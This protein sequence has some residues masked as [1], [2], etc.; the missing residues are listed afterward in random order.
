MYRIN[1]IMMIFSIL[2][3]ATSCISF[4]TYHKSSKVRKNFKKLH[5]Q[6][7]KFSTKLEQ[8]YNKQNMIYRV[9]NQRY[10]NILAQKHP[11][12]T[13]LLQKMKA[14]VDQ[15]KTETTT[16][17]A[18]QNE[19]ITLTKG[20]KKIKS[21]SPQEDQLKKLRAKGENIVD[22]ING[23]GK[24]YQKYGKQY[25]KLL[26]KAGVKRVKVKKMRKTLR[27]SDKKLKKAV[28]KLRKKLR[29]LEN[30]KL[31]QQ[32]DKI[33]VLLKSVETKWIKA[34]Q[35][36]NRLNHRLTGKKY[37]YLID[38]DSDLKT[39]KKIYKEIKQIGKQI[40]KR[41]KKIK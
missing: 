23:T 29:K 25:N 10:N 12:T 11:K 19:A 22:Q 6:V 18:L 28:K 4:N 15:S 31:N 1:R 8:D 14:V 3:V 24:R 39:L 40:N 16:S 13:Q 32:I 36:I 2:F 35:I 20:R 33:K 30:R 9:I 38:Q 26:K 17:L 5:K 27:K 21:G 37:L 41:L 34:Q 7:V